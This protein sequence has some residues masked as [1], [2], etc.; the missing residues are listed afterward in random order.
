[1]Q[2]STARRCRPCPTAARRRQALFVGSALFGLAGRDAAN[3]LNGFE[4]AAGV[5]WKCP[6]A[7]VAVSVAPSPASPSP[8]DSSRPVPRATMA[9][10]DQA[11]GG[12]PELGDHRREAVSGTGGSSF[13]RPAWRLVPRPG[14]ACSGPPSDRC[15]AA[16][17][18]RMAAS[19]RT[20]KS[21]L[22]TTRRSRTPGNR[23]PPTT[24]TTSS[25]PTRT[26]PAL[27]AQ[28]A[29]DR[30]LDG[31]GRRR[32]RQAGRRTRSKTS[33]RDSAR[34]ADLPAPLRRGVVDG[35]S[36]GRLPARRT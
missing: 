24:T 6:Q 14:R 29:Q 15:R 20:S 10:A 28:A 23:S 35:D 2:A 7:L 19:S 8:V 36:V 26:I 1:M 18:R 31:D 22:S 5:R 25:A 16:S 27:N 34:G 11:P 33:S 30:A 17:P 9:H 13:A 4:I 3:Q 12:H 32:G 21:A